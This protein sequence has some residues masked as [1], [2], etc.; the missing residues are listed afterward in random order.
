M[1]S[2][3]NQQSEQ[4][5]CNVR[6]EKQQELKQFF[7]S[8]NASCNQCIQQLYRDWS[9]QK[10]S[11]PLNFNSKVVAD[12]I[13]GFSQGNQYDGLFKV[14]C[15]ACQTHEILQPDF[16]DVIIQQYK[17]VIKNQAQE[18]QKNQD[19]YRKELKEAQDKL[20]DITKSYQQELAQKKLLQQAINNSN[21][22]INELK[23]LISQQQAEIKK[24]E[25]QTGNDSKL[26]NEKDQIIRVLEFQAGEL[27][28]KLNSYKKWSY[29]ID[30]FQSVEQETAN[31]TKSGQELL[32]MYVDKLNSISPF[33]LSIDLEKKS[34]DI[35][36]Q[37]KHA[38]IDEESYFIESQR[39]QI[40]K[41][42]ESISEFAK[43]VF[44][45][46]SGMSKAYESTIQSLKKVGDAN[47]KIMAEQ[48]QGK[49]NGF[50]IEQL[51]EIMNELAE[52]SIY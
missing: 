7:E 3:S 48:L 1:D 18:C 51:K 4:S 14:F 30:L 37:I 31:Y 13:Y 36:D 23:S 19:Q 22:L 34:L 12:I 52:V 17:N 2:L 29:F 16:F 35:K 9:I 5:Y 25:H 20:S 40:N 49:V 8:S 11:G 47:S 10:L 32:Q 41:N 46:Q 42:L 15:K 50:N 28:S 33:Q 39:V 45:H 6:D 38:I 43:I 21:G 24:L 26:L 27:E 44:D